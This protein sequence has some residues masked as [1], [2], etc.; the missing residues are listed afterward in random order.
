VWFNN[1]VFLL[2]A[3]CCLII[4]NPED[5]MVHT[6]TGSLLWFVCNIAALDTKDPTFLS[7]HANT[8]IAGCTCVVGLDML[9]FD[10]F[11]IALTLTFATLIGRAMCI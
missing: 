1:V 3:T 5:A 7:I 11:L 8:L 10:G 2:M 4:V 6:T 9:D